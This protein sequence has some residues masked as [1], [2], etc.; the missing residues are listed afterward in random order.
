M[1]RD[2]D[3][4]VPV[5]LCNANFDEPEPIY[6]PHYGK[7]YPIA[8]INLCGPINAPTGPA[9]DYADDPKEASLRQAF[10]TPKPRKYISWDK[11]RRVWRVRIART[12]LGYYPTLSL[13]VKARNAH[14]KLA[15]ITMGRGE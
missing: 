8:T 13:A 3:E 4:P 14:C 5:P 9:K 6:S 15:G 7:L 10:I 12:H 1:F 11:K 2:Y